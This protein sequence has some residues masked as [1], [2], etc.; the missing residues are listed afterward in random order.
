LSL[1]LLKPRRVRVPRD[2]GAV[3][4]IAHAAECDPREAGMSQAG[5]E[6]I[7][8]AV[9]RLYRSGLQPAMSLALRR[10]GKLVL[11]R[12]IGCTAGNLPGERGAQVPLHPDS[13]LC[14]FSA[15]KSVS[16]LLLH[17][18]ADRG[19]LRLEDRVADYIPEFAAQGKGRVT[20]RQLLAHRAGIP[21]LPIPDPPPEIL[22]DWDGIVKIL[23][24][25][26]PFDPDFARQAYH[27]ITVGYIAGE[28]V[29]RIGGIGLREALREWIAEPLGC[30][31]LGYGLA[32]E[33]RHLL[34][35]NAV[36]GPRPLWPLS[37]YV[38][39]AVGVD[40]SAAVDLSNHDAFLSEVVP[41]GNICATADEACR[42]FQMLLDGGQWEGRRV[43]SE[44]AVAEAVRP[45]GR[46]QYDRT[47]L[48][49]LRFSAGFMLG[50]NPFGLYG[51]KCRQA[52]GH[53]GFVSVL[54]WA[55]PQRDIAVALLN[56]GKSLAP[57]GLGGIVRVLNAIARACPQVAG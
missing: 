6:G 45:L 23:C 52:F 57:A 18:L 15:S 56:T 35:R 13:P 10:H 44:A 33:L 28:L 25:A 26:P 1:A 54:C 30:K 51:P 20:I 32:P 31:Y 38:R 14:L 47:L 21:A 17:K 2:L 19:Q 16:A 43:L 40:F 4:R 48:A 46:L 8:S 27:A 41:A 53:L 5:V 36:T 42:V 11:K 12:S 24:E 3:S 22:R 49:P 39:H 34:P 50:E 9:E 37:A 55:D 29:R 7:W